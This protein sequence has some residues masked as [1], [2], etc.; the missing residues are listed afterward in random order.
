M[1]LR[2]VL[3]GAAAVGASAMLVL[4]DLESVESPESISV[5][6]IAVVDDFPE[7]PIFFEEN[8]HSM[9]ELPCAQCPFR[10][11]NEG[12]VVSWTDNKP[13]SLVSYESK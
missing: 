11:V 5:E 13:S 8:T 12:G 4:P 1:F 9:V 3:V 6:S 7:I 10:E 2:S